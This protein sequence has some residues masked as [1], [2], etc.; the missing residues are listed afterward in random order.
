[1]PALHAS[2][3]N[4]AKATAGAATG[5]P[6]F[7]DIGAILAFGAFLTLFWSVGFFLVYVALRMAYSRTILTVNGGFLT[8]TR[9][10]LIASHSKAQEFRC[11][12]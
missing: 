5:K 6:G 9:V 12:S 2:W 7:K 1:M 10:G 3:V 8:V 4:K 11:S